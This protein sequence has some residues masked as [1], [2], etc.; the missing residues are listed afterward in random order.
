MIFV[1]GGT[2]LLGTHLLYQLSKEGKTVKALKRLG[3]DTS[4]V[5]EI[6]KFYG[7]LSLEQYS[8]IEWVTGDVLDYDSLTDALEGV[9]TI[10]HTAAMVSFHSPRHRDMWN[11]NVEGTK[12]LLDAALE[13]KVEVFCHASSIATLGN[14]ANGSPIT[15]E[16]LWQ[17]DDRHSAYSRSKFRAEM[18]VWRAS[19]EGLNTVIVNPSV[20]IGPGAKNSSSSKIIQLAK[21]GLPFYTNGKTGYVDVR[22]VARA[23]I[24]FVENKIYGERFIISAENKSAR[25]MLSLMAAQLNVKAPSIPAGA[26][27]LWLGM[28]ANRLFAV[29]TGSEP[30]LTRESIKS[31]M[32]QSLYSSEKIIQQLDWNFTPITES[33]DNAIA[34]YQQ[35]NSKV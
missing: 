11:I 23:M 15:E 34:F 8:R 32:G 18:E 14:S 26:W 29:M 7:D 30:V 10:Y 12:N 25:E 17:A 28:V 33:V 20:I 6:F 5:E 21:S 1:T 22:D 19:K 4:A 31:T 9:E 13:K 2:G 35:Q 27:M 3:S 16:D 24:A